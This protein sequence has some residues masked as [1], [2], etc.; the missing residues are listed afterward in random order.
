MIIPKDDAFLVVR[1]VFKRNTAMKRLLH[2]IK[3]VIDNQ[4]T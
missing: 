3:S 1:I 4:R 2:K